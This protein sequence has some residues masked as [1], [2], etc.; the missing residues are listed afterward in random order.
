MVSKR[1]Y[2]RVK[3]KSV[4]VD[5]L[6]AKAKDVAQISLGLDIDKLEIVACLRWSQG[7]FERP[8]SVNNPFEINALVDLCVK[9]EFV[10]LI[11]KLEASVARHWPELTREIELST[12]TALKLLA[13]YGS[14]AEAAKNSELAV[15]Q[16]AL[17]EWYF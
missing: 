13:T 5:Q 6:I 9:N 4:D 14:P 7:Q 16:P 15:Q 2:S 17:K 3:V 11:G 8:W 10:R 1:A 12:P